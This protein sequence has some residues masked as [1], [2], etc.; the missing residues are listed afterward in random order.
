M[1]LKLKHYTLIKLRWVIKWYFFQ[2]TLT[3]RINLQKF[4]ELLIYA[5]IRRLSWV[6]YEVMIN[7]QYQSKNFKNVAKRIFNNVSLLIAANYKKL[8]IKKRSNDINF[9][10]EYVAKIII[11]S[12]KSTSWSRVKKLF[13]EFITFLHFSQSS[14]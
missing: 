9:E 2:N 1:S 7:I 13:K 12:I 11:N 3:E 8:N 4:K 5:I 10:R 6:Q 14:F